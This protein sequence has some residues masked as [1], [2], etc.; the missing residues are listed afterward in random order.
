MKKYVTL[1]LLNSENNITKFNVLIIFFNFFYN[2][3]TMNYPIPQTAEDI[4]ALK[5][6]PVSEELIARAIAGVVKLT[7]SQG[8]TL[9]DLTAQTLAEDPIL[10]RVQRRWL[11]DLI[12]QA[13]QSL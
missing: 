2:L 9:D 3:I 5:A 1:T 7:K 13:W 8:Q 10:D 6:Y 4:I 11:S 12:K